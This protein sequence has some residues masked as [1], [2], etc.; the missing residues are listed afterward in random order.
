MRAK[1]NEM[2]KDEFSIALATMTYIT[3][4]DS[5]GSWL[6]WIKYFSQGLPVTPWWRF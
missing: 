5:S 1:T 6:G 4:L 3:Y 2:R